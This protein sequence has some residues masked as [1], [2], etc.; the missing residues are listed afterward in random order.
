MHEQ[1]LQAE[2]GFVVF[3]DGLPSAGVRKGRGLDVRAEVERLHAGGLAAAQSW[4]DDL[5]ARALTRDEG[6]AVDDISILVLAVL[7][8]QA[9]D[10]VRRLLV[11]VPL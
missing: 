1:P 9:D 6:R 7:P 11:R 3:T 5:L 8:R 2:T 10:G 4:A